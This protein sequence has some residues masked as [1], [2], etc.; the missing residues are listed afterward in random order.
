VHEEG[1][2]SAD[3]G[4]GLGG[5]FVW[6]PPLISGLLKNPVVADQT[7][8]HEGSCGLIQTNLSTTQSI[9]W[10][11][12]T[13]FPADMVRFGLVEA[14]SLPSRGQEMAHVLLPGIFLA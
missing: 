14:V 11:R 5:H 3:P 12:A 6:L 9:S 2:G 1:G 13:F 7:N 8:G 10:T 4:G